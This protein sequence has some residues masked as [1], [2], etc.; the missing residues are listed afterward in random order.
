MS[1]VLGVAAGRRERAAAASERL[2]E[3]RSRLIQADSRDLVHRQ[4]R[5]GK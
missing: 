1:L 4:S 3:L 2:T 5:R